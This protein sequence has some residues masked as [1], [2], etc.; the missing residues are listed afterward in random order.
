ME[1]GSPQV[2]QHL[3][4]PKSSTVPHSTHTRTGDSPNYLLRHTLRDRKTFGFNLANA[5]CLYHRRRGARASSSASS[6]RRVPTTS[7]SSYRRGATTTSASNEPLASRQRRRQL[8]RRGCRGGRAARA[9]AAAFSGEGVRDDLKSLAVAAPFS[10]SHFCSARE[11][12][13]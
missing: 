9:R 6:S 11:L 13:V 4:I 7:T 12:W 1:T 5:L 10:L 3:G 8:E 2:P